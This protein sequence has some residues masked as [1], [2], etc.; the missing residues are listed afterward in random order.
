[1]KD[2]DVILFA[3]LVVPRHLVLHMTHSASHTT[4]AQ[5]AQ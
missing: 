3:Y 2:R 5:R 4:M 1:M